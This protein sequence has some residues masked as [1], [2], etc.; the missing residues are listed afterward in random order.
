MLD[1]NISENLGLSTCESHDV[2]VFLAGTGTGLLV[3]GLA[4]KR[5]SIH[6]YFN[7][8][9]SGFKQWVHSK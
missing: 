9:W 7:G 1:I 8:K 5:C 2:K 6:D 3:Y 4:S